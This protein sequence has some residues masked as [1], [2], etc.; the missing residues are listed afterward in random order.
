MN[1]DNIYTHTPQLR[2]KKLTKPRTWRLLKIRVLPSHHQLLLERR[3][4]SPSR[5]L[6]RQPRQRQ[7]QRAKYQ[8]THVRSTRFLSNTLLA[9]RSFLRWV[10]DV[11]NLAICYNQQLVVCRAAQTTVLCD[12]KE[13]RS[14]AN[15][16]KKGNSPEKEAQ[17]NNQCQEKS[18]KGEKNREGC[19]DQEEG[20][21]A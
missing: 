4:L 14:C 7:A 2:R 20:A 3:P 5:T 9:G 11:A 8:R 13:R 18:E 16:P 10:W 6:M 1:A 19:V 21:S 17:K 15:D 12:R